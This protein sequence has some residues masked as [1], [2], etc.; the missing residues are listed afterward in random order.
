MKHTDILK[1]LEDIENCDEN[2]E[3]LEKAMRYFCSNY[4]I[5]YGYKEALRLTLHDQYEHHAS[6]QDPQD[7]ERLKEILTTN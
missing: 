4:D 3:R 2:I 6:E 5:C 1:L 7:L